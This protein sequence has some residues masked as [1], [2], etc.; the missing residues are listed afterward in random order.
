MYSTLH[1]TPVPK[2]PFASHVC[3]ENSDLSVTANHAASDFCQQITLPHLPVIPHAQRGPLADPLQKKPKYKVF[4]TIP[5]S[6]NYASGSKAI[7]K[8][9]GR[10]GT[11]NKI[12]PAS[13]LALQKI[14]CCKMLETLQRRFYA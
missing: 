7:N 3:A 9:S 2:S 6:I 10:M 5:N 12:N 4:T 11:P 14:P 1:I 13:D 8:S